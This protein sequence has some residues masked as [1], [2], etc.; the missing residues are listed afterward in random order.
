MLLLAEQSLDLVRAR[1]ARS[2]ELGARRESDGDPILTTDAD[3]SSRRDRIRDAL[4]DDAALA[5]GVESF[6]EVYGRAYRECTT[7]IMR[8][9][10][11]TT[12]LSEAS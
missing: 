12:L 6:R 8:Y 7:H 5:E 2:A 11:V 1:W 3:L 9:R 10:P 4:R